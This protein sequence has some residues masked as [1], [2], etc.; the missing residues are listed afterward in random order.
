LVTAAAQYDALEPREALASF[1]ENVA[2]VSDVD[3]LEDRAAAATLITLHAAKGLE[4]PAVFIVGAEEAIL[5]HARA[6][7]NPEQMEEERRL[8]Y[9]GMTRAK[10]RLTLTHARRR[11]QMGM[12]VYNPPSRFL[13]DIP[14]RLVESRSR[15][16]DFIVRRPSRVNG[17]GRPARVPV[18]PMQEVAAALDSG[19][20]T[21]EAG[22]R[23]RH[24][25]FGEGIVVG[26]R[27][28]GGDQ[29]V[30]VAFK[31][32]TGVKRLMVS[33]ARLERLGP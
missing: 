19:A 4:F 2:L 3:E 30:T 28:N 21:F 22:D 8:I 13:K 15:A 6:Y 1:L 9:V 27:L 25:K 5:P 7:D 26:A 31:G 32:E 18:V 23:V 10:A 29:E 17:L 33:Y 14:E 12:P 11:A 24:P 20:R 16:D